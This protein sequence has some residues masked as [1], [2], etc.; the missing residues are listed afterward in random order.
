MS[1]IAEALNGEQAVQLAQALQPD[2]IIMD[3]QM[4]VMDGIT[5]IQQI[6]HANP[7]ARILVLTSFPEDDKVFN[8]IKAGAMGYLLKEAPPEQLVESVQS[9]QGGEVALHPS[10]ARRLMQEIKQPPAQTLAEEP[11]TP[12]ELEVLRCLARGLSNREIAEELTISLRTVTTHVRNI[13]DKLHLANRT[14]AALYA[15]DQKFNSK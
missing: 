14:Q 15:V 12:R 2:V 6:N 4:P 3:I 10:I 13:L 8:A 7:A 9:V 1:V 11:L 5:A